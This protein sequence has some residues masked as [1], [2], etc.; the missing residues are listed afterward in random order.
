MDIDDIPPATDFR[1]VIRQR[2][3]RCD[4]V[5]IVIGRSWLTAKDERGQR[6]LLNALDTHRLEV[7]EAL[8][9]TAV[10]VPVLVEGARHPRAEDLPKDLQPLA[11]LNATELTERRFAE[12][13]TDLARYI[14]KSR[15]AAKQPASRRRQIDP[16]RALTGVWTSKL[17]VPE[18]NSTRRLD[19]RNVEVSPEPERLSASLYES[20]RQRNLAALN[21]WSLSPEGHR[22]L[23]RSAGLCLIVAAC[24]LLDFVT[25]NVFDSTLS[26]MLTYAVSFSLVGV[27]CLV[28]GLSRRQ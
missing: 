15:K 24:I 25:F 2:L 8:K 20:I 1:D 28:F 27:I 17:F 14:R 26:Y 9:S 6:R 11:R 12:D 13:V 7:A 5:I 4:F 3:E 23:T 19:W 21:R 22:T 16:T 18:P 10:V